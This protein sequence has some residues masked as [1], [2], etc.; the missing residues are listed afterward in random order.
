MPHHRRYLFVSGKHSQKNQILIMK[1]LTLIL[2]FLSIQLSSLSLLAQKHFTLTVKLP[3]AINAEKIEAWL[4]DGKELKQIK[5]QSLIDKQMVLTGNY[6]SIHAEVSLQYPPN[7]LEK[8]FVKEFF[9]DEK[10]AIITFT[11][12]G[13]SAFGNYSLHN[14]FDFKNEKMQ[15]DDYCAAERK[16]AIDYEN[17][18]GD[19]IF[20]GSDT[21]V[22]KYYFKVL[23]PAVGRKELLYI[24]NHP[25]SYYSF[26]SFRTDVVKSNL[27]SWDSLLMV[28]NSF[29]NTFKY[30]DEGNDL[31]AFLHRRSSSEKGKAIEFTAKDIHKKTVSLSQF[32]G[33]KY[34]LL[35]FWAIWCS[36]CVH[37]LPAL[38]EISNQYKSKD[39]Q[40]ISIALPPSKTADYLGTI[41][42]FQMNWIHVYNNPDLVNKYGN[43]STPRLCLIDKTGNMVYD[44]IGFKENQDFPLKELKETLEKVIHD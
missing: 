24:M 4:D 2:L 13:G 38:K 12:L 23:R 44:K 39:L 30:S 11:G 36:P 40:I 14:V 43:A 3:K 9:V 25:Q 41:K 27:T 5:P 1:F 29:P 17:Q 21:A 42:K 20:S 28:F 35:H 34:V 32:A 10:P 16:S 19:K 8:G 22:R 6:Y 33:K 37:E 15:M 7:G 26:Y 18:Y 31:N